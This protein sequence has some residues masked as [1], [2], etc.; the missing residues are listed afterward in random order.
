[1]YCYNVLYPIFFIKEK[2]SIE[3]GACIAFILKQLHIL[4]HF[5]PSFVF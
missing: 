1:M 5:K 4:N 2:H 3:N